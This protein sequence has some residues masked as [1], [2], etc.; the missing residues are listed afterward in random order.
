MGCSFVVERLPV[1][2]G[3]VG[4]TPQHCPKKKKK[5]LEDGNPAWFWLSFFFFFLKDFKNS[6]LLRCNW[7]KIDFKIVFKICNLYND[8]Q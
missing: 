8:I 2:C 1:V 7:H 5:M 4:S 6:V 3:A